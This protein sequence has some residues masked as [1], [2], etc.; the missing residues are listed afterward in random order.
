[1]KRNR[2]SA[3]VGS[4]GLLVTPPVMGTVHSGLPAEVMRHAARPSAHRATQPSRAS[5]RSDAKRTPGNANHVM[6]LS[7]SRRSGTA[8]ALSLAGRGS[9]AR[10]AA[11]SNISAHRGAPSTHRPT[12]GSGATG[13]STISTAAHSP[14]AMGSPSTTIDPGMSATLGGGF[15]P[16]T[17]VILKEIGVAS[18]DLP[19]AAPTL[20]D[21]KPVPLT[22]VLGDNFG[23]SSIGTTPISLS[24][25]PTAFGL[26][27][28]VGVGTLN[29]L[30]TSAI[31]TPATPGDLPGSEEPFANPEPGT[32]G[33]WLVLGGMAICA[34]YWRRRLAQAAEHPMR[35]I[36]Q[37]QQVF[38]AH[39]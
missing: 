27:A 28:L 14:L 19:G 25:T 13:S 2:R 39:A 26:D 3:L 7:S 15:D 31:L 21:G 23:H 4:M 24:A 17:N 18:A 12:V 36:L 11:S 1:M 9:S 32:V 38:W 29:P 5:R 6:S 22:P 16:V 10:Q 8:S 37:W 30:A 34:T 20:N 35:A 33:M